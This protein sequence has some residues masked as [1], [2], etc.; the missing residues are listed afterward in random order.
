MF[1]FDARDIIS[2][3]E[4]EAFIEEKRIFLSDEMNK[5]FDKYK[6]LEI[7]DWQENLDDYQTFRNEYYNLVQGIISNVIAKFR[8]HLPGQCLIYQFGSFAKRTERLLSDFDL[9]ICYDDPK[10][11]IHQ[12]AEKLIAYTLVSI[13]G[14]SID[15][16]HGKFQHYP[17]MPELEKYTEDDNNY[18]LVFSDGLIIFRCGPETFHE[19]LMNI[20][21]V[22]DYKSLIKGYEEKYR[23]KC[24]IDC[25]YSNLIM[26]NTTNHDFIGDLS[27]LEDSYDIFDGY[28]FKSNKSKLDRNFMVSDLKVMLKKEGMVQFYIFIAYLRKKLNFTNDYNMD[29]ELLWENQA[30]NNFFGKDFVASARITFLNFMLYFNRVEISLNRRA[31][32]LSSRCYQTFDHK[33]INKI[34]AEDW[35]LSTTIE[36]VVDSKNKITALIDEGVK[37]LQEKGMYEKKQQV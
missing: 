20:E 6:D 18:K 37:L 24:D 23:L 2:K 36:K 17:Q 28:I 35:G 15:K 34:L 12:V 14:Y 8:G 16:F 29:I 25:L 22:R 10:T 19:N 31:I 4:I 9:T 32:P 21:N 11:Q 27:D 30:L 1:E 3:R 7:K 5:A 26:E 13:F 33:S